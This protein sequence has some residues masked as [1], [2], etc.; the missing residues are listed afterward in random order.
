M[1]S[2]PFTGPV[3]PFNNP[4]INPQYFQPGFFF[5]SSI[6]NGTTTT[7]TTTANH[8]F[9]VGQTVRLQIPRVNLSIEFN[10]QSGNVLSIPAANQVVLDI[11][12]SFYNLFQTSTQ[13]NQPQIVAIG[14]LNSGAT[15]NSGN[16]NQGTY[17][18][19]AFINISPL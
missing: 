8:N 12:S 19:G 9:V 4:P 11:N 3:P 18:P 2:N 6:S 16:V 1:T 15:N 17:I 10:E 5:I 14:D 13:P 7:I